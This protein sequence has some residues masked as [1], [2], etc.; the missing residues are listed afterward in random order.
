[1]TRRISKRLSANDTGLTGGH[2]AGILIPKT[3]DILSFFPVLGTG[4][5]NPRITLVVREQA[6]GTRWEFTF[7]YYN[8]L[9]FGGTRN[10]YRLTGMTRYLRAVNAKAGDELVF[11]K[12]GNGSVEIDCVRT[13][14][15]A[16][17]PE[18]GA[19]LVLGGG[20]KIITT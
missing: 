15:H 19:V 12:D 10:E 18:D 14:P 7:I 6:D 4:T 16:L 5:K 8:N 11:S 13:R 3:P 17:L 20:W 2:Q 1:M 9:L